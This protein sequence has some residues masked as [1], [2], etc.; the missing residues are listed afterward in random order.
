MRVYMLVLAIIVTFL[1]GEVFGQGKSDGSKDDVKSSVSKPAPAAPK[2]APAVPKAAPVTTP[3]AVRVAPPKAAV[4]PSP[5]PETILVTVNGIAIRQRDVNKEVAP[6]KSRMAASGR[7][8]PDSMVKQMEQRVVQMLVE[9]QIVKDKIASEGIVITDAQIQTEAEDIAK[10]RGMSVEEF[11][12]TLLE[13]GGVSKAD[14]HEQMRLGLGFKTLMKKAMGTESGAVTEADAKAYYDSNIGRYTKEAQAKASH[15]LV[16]GGTDEAGKAAAKAEADKLLKLVKDGGDFAEL[17]KAHSSCPSSKDGGD[18]GYFEKGRMVPE[19]SEAAFSM[20]VGD[21]SDV[22]ETQFGYHII[23]L[24]DM[25][26][27]GTSTFEDE[28]A[29]IIKM[30]ESNKEREFAGKYIE[31]VKGKAK[32]AWA[33]GFEPRIPAT[34]PMR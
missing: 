7:L 11:E 1:S 30:L 14:F 29:N 12:K 33:A 24:T 18:L 9:K 22:V 25:K 16:K 34:P 27:A 32:I 5:A 8:V 10:K 23:K 31:D 28:K 17:A 6:Q 13:R 4:V 3:K 26:T 20:K 21:V 15:I 2:A 19:F